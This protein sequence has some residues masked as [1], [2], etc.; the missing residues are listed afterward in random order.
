MCAT[1]VLDKV[2]KFSSD[3]KNNSP[4]NTNMSSR[5][6]LKSW[7]FTRCL[8]VTF[9]LREA[10]FRPKPDSTP[11]FSN[12]NIIRWR[13]CETPTSMWKFRRGALL[14]HACC[15]SLH[16]LFCLLEG[17]GSSA[18]LWG[19]WG[20]R[21]SLCCRVVWCGEVWWG[22]VRMGPV[23]RTTQTPKRD[24]GEPCGRSRRSAAAEIHRT[25]QKQ[26]GALNCCLTTL[27]ATS[28]LCY[29]ILLS[30]ITWLI[31]WVWHP[32]SW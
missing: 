32:W 4:T 7:H 12:C 13:W 11:T 8:A 20:F 25:R 10:T 19:A 18:D 16:C 24:G 9:L 5:A 22:V 27:K 2:Q 3:K 6:D 21:V 29:Y 1:F 17:T 30:I 26:A 28:I 14:W 23:Y 15:A 31:V